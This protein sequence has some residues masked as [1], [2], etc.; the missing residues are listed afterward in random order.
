MNKYYASTLLNHAAFS[1]S[2]KYT[3]KIKKCAMLTNY[4][5]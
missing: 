3:C 1:A 2:G 4:Y 5:I